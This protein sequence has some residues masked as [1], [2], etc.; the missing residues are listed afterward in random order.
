MAMNRPAIDD[1]LANIPSHF[2]LVVAASLRAT[3]I[4]RAN[5]E[6]PEPL[7]HSLEEIAAG[8]V[9][10]VYHIPEPAQGELPLDTEELT[11]KILNPT[12]FDPPVHT[13]LPAGMIEE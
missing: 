1:L 2:E 3:E 12:K 4:K 10:V 6:H 7:Q 8:K 9:S 13:P 5:R 11:E